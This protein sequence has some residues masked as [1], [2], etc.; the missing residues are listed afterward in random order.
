MIGQDNSLIYHNDFVAEIEQVAS[1]YDYLF[2]NFVKNC[3]KHVERL[4]ENLLKTCS[5]NIIIARYVF[6][7]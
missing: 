4:C 1:M 3:L 2:Q 5:F 7:N 6:P